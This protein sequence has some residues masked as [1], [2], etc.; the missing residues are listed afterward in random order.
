MV[1]VAVTVAVAEVDFTV[2][3]AVDSAAAV[4]GTAAA[5]GN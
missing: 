3:A 4:E 2:G 5:I 1:V